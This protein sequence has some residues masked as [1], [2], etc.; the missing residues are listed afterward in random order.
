MPKLAPRNYV[1]MKLKE[2]V[3]MIT[4]VTVKDVYMARIYRFV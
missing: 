3:M 2:V 4:R 1:S